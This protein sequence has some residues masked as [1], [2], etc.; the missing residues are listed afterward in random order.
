VKITERFDFMYFI[1][2]L[3]NALSEVKLNFSCYM[4]QQTLQ[5]SQFTVLC[6]HYSVRKLAKWCD[7]KCLAVHTYCRYHRARKGL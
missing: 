5:C 7:W 6:G 3:A 1:V 2:W 4:I